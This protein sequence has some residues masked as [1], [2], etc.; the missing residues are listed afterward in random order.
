M[1]FKRITLPVWKS[2]VR[3]NCVRPEEGT[4]K[5]DGWERMPLQRV[6]RGQETQELRMM[7]RPLC[8]PGGRTW[9]PLICSTSEKGQGVWGKGQGSG[10]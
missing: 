3:K 1:C 7:T 2:T 4:G 6:M 10:S 8:W 9:H 5:G